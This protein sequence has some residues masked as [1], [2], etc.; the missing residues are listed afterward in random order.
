MEKFKCPHCN[1]EIELSEVAK[2]Q[3][4]TLAAQEIKNAKKEAEKKANQEAKKILDK[5]RKQK[6]LEIKEANQKVKNAE[7]KANE[8]AKKMLDKERKL[9]ETEI[10]DA[11][12][13]ERAIAL[14][15]AQKKLNEEKALREKDRNLF[16]LKEDRHLK[17]IEKLKKRREQGL[18]TDQG[19]AQE[20]SL[21]DFLE[22]VFK[23]FGDEIIPIKKGESGGD[24]LQKINYQGVHIGNI[25]YESKETGSFSSKWIPKLQSDMK[26]SKA[27]IGIIFTVAL[28]KDFDNEKG[29]SQKGNIFL[30]KYNY[31]TLRYL[32]LTRRYMMVNLYEKNQGQKKDN[33]LSA[34][35]FFEAANTQ[36]IFH[37]VD[38]HFFNIGQNI[39]KSIN[40]LNNAKK[41][42]SD[43]DKFLEEIFKLTSVHG[44]KRKKK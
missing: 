14:N 29:F 20:M 12:K 24:R 32:A 10:K 17:D 40:N 34:D 3:A 43:M 42:F 6:D 39:D 33:K 38:D 11:R 21:G 26:D 22:K 31:D 8:E 7:K 37:L 30:C 4:K 18:T 27:S 36:N 28:P 44:L 5:E 13:A 9:K 35:E 19:T 41:N 16:K 1:K 2:K 25:L 23:E 15:E